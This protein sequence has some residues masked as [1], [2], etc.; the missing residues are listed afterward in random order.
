MLQDSEEDVPSAPFCEELVRSD[1][2]LIIYTWGR[3]LRKRQPDCVQ[4]NFN[5]AILNG[6]RKGVNLKK[7]DGRSEEV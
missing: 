4:R 6:R 2:P 7:L 5:A 1:R 3:K